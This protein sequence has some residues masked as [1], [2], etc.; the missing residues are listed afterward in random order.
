MTKLTAQAIFD[1]VATHAFTQGKKATNA[2][3]T[4]MYRTHDDNKCF[5]GCL[6]KDEDYLPVFDTIGNFREVIEKGYLKELEPFKAMLIDLQHLHDQED[7]WEDNH[8]LIVNRVWH[9]T[10]AMK[11]G[12]KY[13]ATKY[14]LDSKILDNLKFEGK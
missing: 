12:L 7:I 6:I 8:K 14:N 4:C 11:T 3:G 10:E 13:I 1:T 9:S 2:N 5:V